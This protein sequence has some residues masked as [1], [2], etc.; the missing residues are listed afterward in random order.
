MSFHKIGLTILI[1]ISNKNSIET[2]ILA[3]AGSVE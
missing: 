1:G 3:F 2:P